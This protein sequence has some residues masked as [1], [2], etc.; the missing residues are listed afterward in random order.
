[1]TNDRTDPMACGSSNKIYILDTLSNQ[2]TLLY[3]ENDKTIPASDA[4]K[5]CDKDMS[6]TATQGAQLIFKYHTWET[7]GMCDQAWADPERTYFLDTLN[8]TQGTQKFPVPNE[9]YMRAL[10]KVKECQATL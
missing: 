5:G 10:D 4:V 8:V 6:L 1:M 7:G 3:E 2:A 9:L